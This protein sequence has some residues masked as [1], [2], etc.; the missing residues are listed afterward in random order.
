MAMSQN[1]RVL[2]ILFE[3]VLFIPI[4]LPINDRKTFNMPY[5]GANET[6]QFILIKMHLRIV[7]VTY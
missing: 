5:S 7:N 2:A 1:Y 6:R 3:C 4:E